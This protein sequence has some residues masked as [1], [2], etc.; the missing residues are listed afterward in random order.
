MDGEVLVTTPFQGRHVLGVL[1]VPL[2]RLG[3]AIPFDEILDRDL[4]SV[5]TVGCVSERTEDR[6]R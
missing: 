4:T 1:R 2:Q 5:Q 6:F 3:D